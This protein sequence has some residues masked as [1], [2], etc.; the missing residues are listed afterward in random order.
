MKTNILMTI[1][2]LIFVL[3]RGYSQN[4]DKGIKAADKAEKKLELAKLIENLVDSKQF[5]FVAT[6]ALPMGGASIDL[7]TNSNYVKFDPDYIDS[8]MPFFG[9]AYS[10]DYR[11]DTGMKFEGKPELFTIKRLKK[12]R[13][14]DILT[15]V[16]L[17]RDTYDLRLEV[18][19][20]GNSTLTISSFNRSTIS[21]VG[22]IVSPEKPKGETKGDAKSL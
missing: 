8:Y 7:T 14:Y 11:N 5:I 15:K 22:Q 9:Q 1:A 18:G 20:E 6:R 21:Y 2:F 3:T 4:T 13:G 12:N 19:L 17:A 10:V 16:S